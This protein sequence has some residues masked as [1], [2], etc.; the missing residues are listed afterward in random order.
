ME[1]N[2]MSIVFLLV[3]LVLG[4]IAVIAYTV[5]SGARASQKAEKLLNDAKKEADKHKRDSLLELKEESFKLKQETDKEIKERKA[6]LVQ[7][8]ER[9]MQR[10]M[11]P[12]NKKIII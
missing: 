4:A 3:G 2:A 9:L 10:E 1:L 6:E 8:E 7:S 5:L 12:L 11:K